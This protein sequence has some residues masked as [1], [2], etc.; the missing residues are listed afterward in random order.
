MP[1]LTHTSIFQKMFFIVLLMVTVGAN[2]H[3]KATKT[4][5]HGITIKLHGSASEA[6]AETDIP[7]HTWLRV[8]KNHSRHKHYNSGPCSTP[9]FWSNNSNDV[10]L[11]YAVQTR[12]DRWT[13][14]T[15][16][17][18]Y[19]K[20]L[21]HY[22]TPASTRADQLHPTRVASLKNA[23]VKTSRLMNQKCWQQ[24]IQLP[25]PQYREL[26]PNYVT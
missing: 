12:I 26:T 14:T 18:Y 1:K 19:M 6:N 10:A 17:T 13:E 25:T 22:H 3:E 4:F 2:A 16:L 15:A 23:A 20:R 24:Q 11:I 5:V 21:A 8:D 7:G 9:N